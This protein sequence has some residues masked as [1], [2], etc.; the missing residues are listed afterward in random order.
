MHNS[1]SFISHDSHFILHKLCPFLPF[2]S[3]LWLPPSSFDGSSSSF[4]ALLNLTG[5]FL[6]VSFVW[7]RFPSSC[8]YFARVVSC[9]VGGTPWIWKSSQPPTPSASFPLEL[10]IGLEQHRRYFKNHFC[11]RATETTRCKEL[12]FISKWITLRSMELW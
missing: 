12:N 11:D 9:T 7:F 8:F 1:W 6:I 4:C 10:F 5:F 3:W 2:P